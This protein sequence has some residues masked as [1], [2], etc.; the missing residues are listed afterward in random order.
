MPDIARIRNVAFVGPHHSGKTT[1]VEALL[2]YT[3]AIPRRGT[4]ADG[5]TTTD[6][7]P[8]CIDRAQ[9]TCVGFAHA[10]T[11][12]LDLTLI[13][14]PGF[15]DFQEETK[16]ALL[17]ADAA[18]VVVEADPARVRQTRALVEFLDARKMPHCF[19]VNKLDRPGSDFRGTL[20]ALSTTFGTRVVAEHL[21]LGEAET[22]R[23]YI[24]L[25][26]RHA[27]VIEAGVTTEIPIA[28]E[29]DGTVTEARTKLLEA[30]GDFDDHLLEELLEGI[31]PP[32]DEVRGDLREE[33][34]HDQIVPVL[35]G[36]GTADIGVAALLDAIATLFPAPQGDPQASLVAQVCKTTIH[37]QSG[38]LSIAR[39]WNG[40]LTADVALND[41]TRN[42]RVRIGGLYRLQGKKQEPITSAGPGEI[43]A[44]GRLDGVL[45]GDT[46]TANGDATVC[47]VPLVATPLFAVAIRPKE[48]LDE[49][50]LSQML[51]KLVEEDPTLAVARAEFTSEL[52]LIGAGE[53]HV[54]TSTQRL[55]RKYHLALETSPPQIAY[56]ETITTAIDQH[57]RYKHQTGGHGQFAD[58]VL[59]I[60]PRERGAGV[61]FEEKI[62]GGVVPRVFFPAVEKGVREA[63]LHGPIARF[64]VV[65]IHV[66]LVDG[67]F[68]DVDS[69]EAAFKTAAAMAM[70]DALPKCGPVLLEPL[71]HVDAIV[72]EES[73]SAILASLTAKRGHVLSFEPTETR[74]YHRVS[75]VAP[76][77]ELVN[78][79]TEL[80]T[81]TQGL[82]TYAWRHERFEP[83][84]PKL[85]Q[86]MRETVP[87]H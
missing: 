37:P 9:S 72:P 73:A 47:D 49:A 20:E 84:P 15:V 52:Q 51:A 40:T 16:L 67:A 45:T 71:V 30:L 85:A 4:V 8:E 11:A 80:R 53:V 35:V 25:A 78:Y 69:S 1:L 42:L 59:R 39:I 63:L 14:C 48:R 87:A 34:S 82:G 60:E 44:I 83:A 43:V 54:A 50:K 74:G 17:A 38:K 65:D 57:S 62:V 19:F 55:S 75:A 5:T 79:I 70:R 23:G 6:Y 86:T 3:K 29:L 27:Y 28:D 24:D 32:L 12:A 10:T 66:T 13:D 76:Q 81:A 2:A 22:F 46:L 61:S 68:H 31:E 58:V 77:N 18:V 26:E 33:T 41:T 56:R 7:E 21:P 36:S 64:P